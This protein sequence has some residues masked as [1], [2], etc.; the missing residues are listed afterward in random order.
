VVKSYRDFQLNIFVAG[1]VTAIIYQVMSHQLQ[2][3]PLKVLDAQP[4]SSW[5]CCTVHRLAVCY[6][7]DVCHFLDLRYSRGNVAEEFV[8]CRW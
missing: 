2:K 5:C 4:L 1:T 8:V 7:H 3:S 6:N